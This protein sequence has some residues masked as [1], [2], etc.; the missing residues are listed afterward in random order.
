M[1]LYPYE[2]ADCGP[3]ELWRSFDEA[4]EPGTCPGCG[5]PAPR[6]IAI[7]VIHGA[8]AARRARNAARAEP[9]LVSRTRENADRDLGSGSTATTGG[10]RLRGDGKR[11]WMLGD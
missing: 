2:C 6:M 9:R 8:A 4:S 11:P 5:E 1:P 3:F 10:A 7:P